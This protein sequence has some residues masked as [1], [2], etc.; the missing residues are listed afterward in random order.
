MVD[1]HARRFGAALHFAIMRAGP[2]TDLQ[3][4]VMDRLLA[5][6]PDGVLEHGSDAIGVQGFWPINP[7]SEWEELIWAERYRDVEQWTH[8]ETTAQRDQGWIENQVNLLRSGILASFYS[9]M[10][11][12]DT[13]GDRPR[14]FTGPDDPPIAVHWMQLRS[15]SPLPNL[16]TLPAHVEKLAEL[17]AGINAVVQYYSAPTS[18]GSDRENASIWVEYPT[19]T[20]MAVSLGVMACDAV[21][22]LWRRD[23][24]QLTRMQREW[25]LIEAKQDQA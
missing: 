11:V 14:L 9:E 15:E 10:Q 1:V 3:R 5:S 7:E 17:M 19:M 4:D 2:K 25:Y 21:F 8:A 12:E 24:L 22:R 16:T 6:V 18:A 13:I 20:D 23:L